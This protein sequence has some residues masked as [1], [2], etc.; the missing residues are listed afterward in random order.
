ML[1]VDEIVNYG[2]F[3]IHA[4]EVI[5]NWPRLLSLTLE[6]QKAGD[7]KYIVAKHP[8]LGPG[9]VDVVGISHQNC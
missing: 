5:D 3:N 8:K 9:L 4:E 7:R 2:P 1:E 6:N